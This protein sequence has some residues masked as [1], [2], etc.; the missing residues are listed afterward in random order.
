MATSE[1]DASTADP[2]EPYRRWAS[3]LFTILAIV[4]VVGG[5]VV[6]AATPIPAQV[7][8]LLASILPGVLALLAVVNALWRRD[9]WAVHAIAPLCYVIIVAGVIRGLAALSQ[10]AIPVPLEVIG[11]AMVLTRD[12]DAA[13]LPVLDGAHRRRA[14]VAVAA[15]IVASL[16][17]YAG[18]ALADGRVFG[19]QPAHLALSVTV[20][21]AGAAEPGTPIPVHVAWSWARG[22]PFPPATDGLL[23]L[24]YAGT[25]GA[26]DADT[27]AVVASQPR[28]SDETRIW[29]GGAGPASGALQ[30]MAHGSP[31]IEYGIDQPDSGLLDGAI[32]LELLMADPTARA[33]GAEV[34]AWYAHGDRW[35]HRSETASCSS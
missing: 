9:A 26:V 5:I 12:H 2:L 8:V 30:D 27:G 16:L 32:D 35:L 7:T 34:W 21:C 15:V 11:A 24:W 4:G 17:P 10:G 13:L 3:A 1:P 25:Y 29:P 28:S 33:G 19:A 14:G 22:E 18:A 23:V 6:L 31:S 20:D